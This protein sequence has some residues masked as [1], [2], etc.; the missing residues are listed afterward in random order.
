MQFTIVSDVPLDSAGA[1]CATK[2]ENRGESAI[3]TSAQKNKKQINRTGEFENK[4]S[5]EIR[6]H[7]QDKHNAIVAIRFAL[8]C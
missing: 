2:V 4:K 3:T 5:G 7:R 1:L 8:K 6:Q